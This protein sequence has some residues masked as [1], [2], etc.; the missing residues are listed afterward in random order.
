MMK[1]TLTI[2]ATALAL[3][4]GSTTAIAQQNNL[5]EQSDGY[6]WPTEPDV[7]ENLKQWQDLKFG[8]LLHW[9]IYAV[10]EIV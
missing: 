10:P 4:L 6:E 1:R 7:V 3:L 9:G 8:V 2:A 5:H